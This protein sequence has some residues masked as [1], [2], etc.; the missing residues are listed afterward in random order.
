MHGMPGR[1]AAMMLLFAVYSVA[2]L[3]AIP[4]IVGAVGGWRLLSERFRAVEEFRGD[5]SRWFSASMRWGVQYN[6]VLR[7]GANA[8]G[9]SIA[10]QLLFRKGPVPLFI[11]WN[12]IR[13]ERSGWQYFYLSVTFRLGLEEQIP[14][15][16]SKRIARKLRSAAGDSWP[17]R[18]NALLL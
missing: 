7:L 14:F 4:Y 12:A 9:V 3:V 17:D 13:L 2:L 15:R 18:T 5:I 1:D 8:E 10:P 16:V 6:N 11:P